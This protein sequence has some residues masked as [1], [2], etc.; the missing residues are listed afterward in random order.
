MLRG[1][2]KDFDNQPDYFHFTKSQKPEKF[3]LINIIIVS[4]RLQILN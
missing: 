3:K 4:N 1:F 2:K